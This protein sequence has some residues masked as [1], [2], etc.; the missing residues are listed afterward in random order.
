MKNIIFTLLLCLI[1][2]SCSTDLSEETARGSIAGSVSDR[3]TGEPVSTVNV[4]L[5]P[6]GHSTVTG[7]DGSF[8]FTELEPKEYTV[9]ISKESYQSN[10]SQILVTAGQPTQAHLLI[11]R[12]P[13]AITADRNLLDFGEE[14]TTLSFTIV[15]TG[16]SDLAYKVEKG[17]CIWMKV[18]PADGNLLYGKTATI[19]VEID[20]SM[21]PSGKNEAMIVVRSTS[22]G[23]NVEVKVAAIGEYRALSSLNTLEATE[24][25]GA[26]VLL[27]GEIT[28]EGAPAYT[29]RGFVWATQESPTLQSKLGSISVPVTSDRHFS[30]RIENLLPTTTYYVRAYLKQNGKVTYGNTITIGTSQQTATVVTSTATAVGATSATLHATVTDD[31]TPAY[32]ERGFCYSKYGEP[33]IAD[34]RRPISGTGKGDYLLQITALEYP[35]TYYARAYVIQSGKPEYGNTVTFTTSNTSASVNISSATQITATSAMLNASVLN[36]GE[37][38]YTERGFCYG[39]NM[40]PTIADHRKVVNGTGT[41]NFSLQI[42]GLDY[43]EHYY[44]RAYVIQEGKPIYSDEVEFTTLH[45]EVTVSTSMPTNVNCSSAQLNGIIGTAGMPAYNIRGFCYSSTNTNPSLADNK[46]SENSNLQGS[47]KTNITNLKEG[48]TYYVRAYAMQDNNVIYGKAL[49]FTTHSAPIIRTNEVTALSP[50]DMGTGFTFGWKATFNA[51]VI[52]TGSPTYSQRGF[53]YGETYNPKVGTDNSIHVSGN[54]KGTYSATVSNLSDYKT[55]YVRA[56]V[57]S[58]DGYV[59]GE[60]ISFRTY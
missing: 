35:Q 38:A 30:W 33:T 7:S 15:N 3:T 39:K 51:S 44:A 45:K 34:N 32:T 29:E 50:I 28:N 37:P 25:T 4:T 42:T 12:I 56:Y 52:S 27:N 53:V 13:A 46:T 41:G 10:T 36:I 11:E 2:C 43:P 54:V 17:N 19:I 6:G 23:G 26:S 31:G 1:Y 48:T 22:G 40:F 18:N 24:I 20:R 58:A 60:N 59:Y 47:F 57:K 14:F 8:S 9:N 21:L 55:Y 49:S 5:L 16:Y